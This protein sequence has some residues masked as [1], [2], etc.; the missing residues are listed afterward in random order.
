MKSTDS[1]SLEE[2]LK[3]IGN[4]LRE[5]YRP[6]GESDIPED[7]IPQ[8]ALLNGLAQ[9]SN[10][11]YSLFDFVLFDYLFCT[12]N[13]A[14]FVGE[15]EQPGLSAQWKDKYW[16]LV[17]DPKSIATFISL[18]TQVL[19]LLAPEERTS[20]HSVVCGGQVVNISNQVLR[21]LYHSHPLILDEEAN[22]LLSFD[23]LE[24]VYPHLNAAAGY[25]IRFESG[26]KI[27]HWHSD[28]GRL[29]PKDIISQREKELILLW[30]KGCTVAEIAELCCVS[31]QTVKNQLNSVRSRL[32]A[33]DNSSLARLCTLSGILPPII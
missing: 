6:G 30:R 23:S 5:H 15:N 12:K 13:I 26:S 24:N 11:V 20:F 16:S 9:T 18:R 22:V 33:R 29:V 17:S 4:K 31:V 14:A 7:I 25:W 2:I 10:R 32:F 28:A 1:N 21:L 27:F 3:K 8:L 19:L